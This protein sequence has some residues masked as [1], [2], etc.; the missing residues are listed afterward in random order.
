MTVNNFKKFINILSNLVENNISFEEYQSENNL[1]SNYFTNKH[2]DA[3][4]LYNAGGI[5]EKEFNKLNSL[6]N[7]L[8]T[9]SKCNDLEK[10]DNRS[11]VNLVRDEN[12]HISKYEFKIYIQ[13]KAP[14]IGTFSRDEMALIYR[15]YSSYGSGLTQK[16]VSRF[17]PEYS[18]YDFRRILRTFNITKASSPFPQHIVEESSKEQLLEMQFREKE[19]DFLRTYEIEKVKKL[20]DQLK[21]CMKENADLR[22]FKDSL[23]EIVSGI[24]VQI[25]EYTKPEKKEGKSVIYIY[26]SDLHVGAS[27]SNDYSLYSNPYDKGEIARRLNRIAQT[28]IELDDIHVF[29]DI[30]ICNLGDSLDSYNGKTAR[31]TEINSELNNKDQIKTYIELMIEFFS[32][33]VTN[34]GA[35]VH[36]YCVGESNHGGDFDYVT[37]YALSQILNLNFDVKC[38]IADKSIE[39]F[40]FNNLTTIYSH[41]NDNK[42]MFKGMPLSINDKTENYI[43]QYIDYNNLSGNIV[44]VKGDLHQSATTYGK[45]FKY[46]SVGSV[47]GSSDWIMSNFGNTKPCCDYSIV[48]TYGR[49]QDGLIYFN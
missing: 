26:L 9:T 13:D 39:H 31:G 19:N 28:I 45:R 30:I 14:L 41:G 24:S 44:F 27:S 34:V 21:K 32:T 5:T 1:S 49:M 29:S 2:R 37:N 4:K 6:Y 33:I 43:N 8:K 25:P 3:K 17:F 12:G 35:Q 7:K 16:E 40:T 22:N 15:L 10:T 46:K 36:Y 23:S 47:Y 11:E 18:L 48:D 38:T 42:N 20:G